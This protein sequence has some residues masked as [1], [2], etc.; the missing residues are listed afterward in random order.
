MQGRVRVTLY[1]R[2]VEPFSDPAALGFD[3]NWSVAP[4]VAAILLAEVKRHSPAT[5]VELG[6]GWSTVLL[7]AALSDVEG[8]H[9]ISIDE[10]A[11]WLERTREVLEERGLGRVCRLL[12]GPVRPA[13]LTE[14]RFDWYDIELPLTP[15]PIDLLFVDGPAN[16]PAGGGRRRY[17]ALPVLDQFLAPDAVVIVDDANRDGERQMVDRWS[18]ELRW[19]VE[20]LVAERGCAVLRRSPISPA[21]AAR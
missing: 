21:P 10:D 7:A 12:H 17:P 19:D 18:T 14:Q 8:A 16:P 11:G 15:R 4:D 2:A 5:V 1:P 13:T 20:W 3:P 6:S 9:V